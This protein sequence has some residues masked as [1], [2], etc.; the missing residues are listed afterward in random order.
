MDKKEKKRNERNETTGDYYITKETGRRE[1]FLGGCVPAFRTPVNACT[2]GFPK[3][4]AAG[5]RGCEPFKYT[6]EQTPSSRA[7]VHVQTPLRAVAD[8]NRPRPNVTSGPGSTTTPTTASSGAKRSWPRGRRARGTSSERQRTCA[9]FASSS[10]GT[11]LRTRREAART[12]TRVPGRT[13]S[14]R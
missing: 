13:P 14:V 1:P 9:T 5:Q 10:S 6:L 12:V 4:S 8:S 11:V 7:L 3:C 2:K